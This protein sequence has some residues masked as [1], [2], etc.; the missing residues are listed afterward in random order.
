[1]NNIWH[2]FK[3]P[4]PWFVLALVYVLVRVAWYEAYPPTRNYDHFNTET[5]LKVLSNPALYPSDPIWRDGGQ[6][7]SLG[8]LFVGTWQVAIA[9]FGD[10]M[11]AWPFFYALHLILY[12]GGAYGLFY[13]LSR[14][15]ALAALFALLSSIPFYL[16]FSYTNWGISSPYAR[17]FVTVQ[18]PY[19]IWALLVILDAPTRPRWWWAAWGV[20]L[21]SIPFWNPVY[22][23]AW[24]EFAAFILLVQWLMGRLT[25][26]EYLIPVGLGGAGFVLYYLSSGANFGAAEGP[27]LTGAEK[28]QL[29][30]GWIEFAGLHFYPWATSEGVA[31]RILAAIVAGALLLLVTAPLLRGGEAGLRRWWPFGL[32]IL[33][34]QIPGPVMM[35]RDATFFMLVGYWLYRYHKLDRGDVLALS[36]LAAVNLG[37]LLQ[38]GLAYYL[39]SEH[40]ILAM[41]SFCFEGYRPIRWAFFLLFWLMLRWSGDLLAHYRGKNGSPLD[42]AAILF[43]VAACASRMGHVG[44]DDWMIVRPVG[45]ED[46]RQALPFIA[47]ALAL[48][49]RTPPHR[50]KLGL[51]LAVMSAAAYPA[52]EF[53]RHLPDFYQTIPATYAMAG[54]LAAGLMLFLL[55]EA[56][57]WRGG[58][59]FVLAIPLLIMPLSAYYRAKPNGNPSPDFN[60]AAAWARAFSPNEALFLPRNLDPMPFRAQS[61]RSTLA[62]DWLQI[63]Y[64]NGPRAALE[65]AV[66][67]EQLRQLDPA[68]P[69]LFRQT[70]DQMGV[71][72]IVAGHVDSI[73]PYPAVFYTAE[74]GIYYPIR[75]AVR[76]QFYSTPYGGLSETNAAAYAEFRAN[77][78]LLPPEALVLMPAAPNS[79]RRTEGQQA[80]I[81][82]IE[83]GIGDR[84][85]QFG[86]MYLLERM[87]QPHEI[88][89]AA[90]AQA[91]LDQWNASKAAADLRAAGVVYL[92]LDDRWWAALGETQQAALADPQQYRLIAEWP[93]LITEFYRLYEVLD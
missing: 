54:I 48:L 55:K 14:E 27:P 57:N 38:S 5:T 64:F 35:S 75:P 86:L 72:F 20:W 12:L 73:P 83:A 13:R 24:V 15:R 22:G 89:W 52:Y 29:V 1:M 9:V 63:Y 23:L 30:K 78:D 19:L 80:L 47:M 6:A 33:M 42:L 49:G 8:F 40:Q 82:Q 18:T 70:A 68:Q 92:L 44:I 16:Y 59:V 31:N 4:G 26:R 69:E 67:G 2:K 65:S 7:Y 76:D 45:Q 28:S 77:V 3:G 50:L 34:L 84:E 61:E 60:A 21:G 36:F 53:A 17:T 79:I 85:A 90:E 62:L 66:L 88:E 93:G 41:A 71:D 74:V 46:L 51:S 25:W 87:R 56:P 37:S 91:A 58:V 43:I 39:F 10:F 11:A 32:I 81:Y